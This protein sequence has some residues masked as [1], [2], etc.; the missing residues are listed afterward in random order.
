MLRRGDPERWRA[1]MTAPAGLRA[2]LMALYAFNLEIARAPWVASEF[3]IAQIRLQWWADAVA[4]IYDGCEV[5]RHT[6]TQPLAM[7]I[8]ARDL[9]RNLFEQTIEVR[10]SDAD[11][12]HPADADA[13]RDYIDRTA[14]H[15]AVLAAGILGE[16]SAAFPVIRKFAFAVGAAAYLR[17]V[18]ELQARGRSPLPRGLDAVALAREGRASLTEARAG[19]AEVSA[20]SLP[21]LVSGRLT[22][23]R[24]RR[25]E[26]GRAVEVSAFT[27]RRL[28]AQASLR[29][30]W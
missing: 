9:P 22:D 13:L 23:L 7:V 29:G 14:G 5:R 16:R 19:R 15:M 28:M 1:A 24:L 17:A 11:P 4:E 12:V 26:A 25:A 10:L 30:R 2:G 20:T 8:R 6:V 3:L 21:V 27:E 18:P